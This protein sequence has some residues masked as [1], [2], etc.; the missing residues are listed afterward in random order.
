MT[1]SLRARRS[2]EWALSEGRGRELKRRTTAEVLSVEPRLRAV[3]TRSC[4]HPRDTPGQSQCKSKI[5]GATMS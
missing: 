1:A 4:T 5:S 3:V 2:M